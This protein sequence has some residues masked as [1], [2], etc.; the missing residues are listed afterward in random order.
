MIRRPPR[1]TLFPYTTLFRSR[2]RA[3][4]AH[5][6]SRDALVP[7]GNHLLAPEAEGE[8]FVAIARAVELGALVIGAPFVVQPAGVVDGHATAGRRFSARAGLH[9]LFHQIRNVRA[10]HVA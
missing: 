1:S 7:A 10:S 2:Q 5:L 8:R 4:A 9:V 3:L 6:H